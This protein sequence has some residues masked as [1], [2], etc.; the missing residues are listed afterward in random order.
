MESKVKLIFKFVILSI[1]S[2]LVVTLSL[3]PMV[4]ISNK[5]SEATESFDDI[6]ISKYSGSLSQQ[7]IMYANDGKTVLAKFYAQNR[8]VVPLSK[9]SKHMID[10]IIAREDKRFYDHHGV[11]IMGTFRALVKTSTSDGG[12]QGGST[13]TQ[14]FVKNLLIDHALQQNDPIGVYKSREQ[15]LFRKIR[16]AGYAIEIEKKMTKDEILEGYLNVAP[17]GPNIYGVEATSRRYFDKHASELTVGEAAL[18]ASITKSP[19]AYSPLSHPVEAKRQRNIVLKLMLDQGSISEDEYKTAKAQRIVDM[20]HEKQVPMGCKTAG[21]SAFFCDWVMNQI[22]NDPQYGETKEDRQNFLYRS[23]LS[24]TTTLDLAYQKNA[25]DAVKKYVPADDSSQLE[26]ALVSIEPGTGKVLAMAQNREYDAA[27]DASDPNNLATAVNYSVGITEGG[28]RG[29]SPGS[30][31][32]P[33]T[34]TDWVRRGHS[35]NEGLG[36]LTYPFNES[37]FACYSGT[38]TWKPKNANG[39]I[40]TAVPLQGLE[41]SWNIP[42]I[43]MAQKLGLCSIAETARDLG[44]VDSLK[45]DLTDPKNMTPS[46]IIGAVNATPLTMANVYATI[47]SGGVKCNPIGILSITDNRGNKITPP[48]ANCKRTIDENVANTMQYALQDSVKYGLARGEAISGFDVGGKTGTSEYGNHLFSAAILKQAST[49]VWV[50]NAEYDKAIERMSIGG[51]YRY[52]WYGMDICVPIFKEFMDATIKDKNLQNIPFS[53][54]DPNLIK[55]S[56]YTSQADSSDDK[57]DDNNKDKNNDKSKSSSKSESKKDDSSA[58][59][60]SSSSSSSSNSSSSDSST[61]KK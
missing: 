27:A 22:L 11:D 26:D 19:S 9:M 43:Q 13:I 37:S 16:E 8:I 39:S 38:G 59:K 4:I 5:F 28:S 50:G 21:I 40:S 44:F 3:I 52:V 54:P 35:L 42:F 14:Q 48:T 15:S 34:L 47:A 29:F 6:D 20:L 61:K 31:M 24:I 46:M 12:T 23:G 53:D 51:R 56:G 60:Q 10:A 32:K 18:I 7:T 2:G 58:K 45:G 49:A 57:D 36:K 30:T 41:R 1:V 55:R 33:I 17:F 25:S